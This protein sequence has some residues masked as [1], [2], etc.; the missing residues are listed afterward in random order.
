MKKY[1]AVIPLILLLGC[2]TS[3]QNVAGKLLAST[4]ATVDT[5]MKGW[6]AY[7][8]AGQA[9]DDQQRQVRAVYGDYQVSMSAAETVY[10]STVTS[11]SKATPSNW[12]N[13]SSNLTSNASKLATTVQTFTT[14]KH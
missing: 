11:G 6:A 4:A 5:V 3:F 8:I 10:L 2:A 13:I 9:S 7:V 14:P 12:S 1:I